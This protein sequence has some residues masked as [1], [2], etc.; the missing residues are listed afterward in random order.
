METRSTGVE[1]KNDDKEIERVE[2]SR[3]RTLTQQAFRRHHI[4]RIL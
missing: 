1:V 2:G 4:Y 3:Q